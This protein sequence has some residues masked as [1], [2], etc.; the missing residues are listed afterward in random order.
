MKIAFIGIRHGHIHALYQLACK[1]PG[2]E[3][4]AACED[5]EPT[6]KALAAAGKI[7]LTHRDWR[8][9]LAEVPCDIVACGDYY[10]RR[11]EI[12][13]AAL[14][15][16]KHVIADKP[17]CTQMAQWKRIAALSAAKGLAV[18]CQLDMRS[19]GNL[20]T[21]RRLIAEGAIGPI[22][23]VLFTGQHPL[24]F[25]TRPG[26]Y[27]E[28]GK[29]GGTINDIAVHAFDA[30]PWVTGRTLA[31]VVAARVWNAS[32]DVCPGFQ[33][34]AQLMLRMD[35]GGGVLGDVSYL[36]PDKVRFKVPQYWRFTFHGPGGSIETTLSDPHVQVAA[37]NQAELRKVPAEG[38]VPHS[39]FESFLREVTGEAGQRS[40]STAEVLE[41]ARVSLAAQAAAD[42]G[43][44]HVA[45]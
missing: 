43:A 25:G 22:Q 5:D 37:A 8:A 45:L 16:G 4:V 17:I 29:H 18:G 36:A 28:P 15:A 14:A 2:V 1:H 39:Y 30:I 35:N 10:A 7:K 21:V 26:W 23:T 31:E 24:Q 6:R 41:A 11:G 34:G 40:P 9:M 42:S 12:L 38:A 27:F 33:D 13:L 3:V 20:R 19:W 44:C 32:P